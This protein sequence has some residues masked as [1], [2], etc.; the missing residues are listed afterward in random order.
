MLNTPRSE[1]RPEL[2]KTVGRLTDPISHD[3]RAAF[4]TLRP[5]VQSLGSP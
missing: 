4:R 2:L 1:I 5:T 3:G